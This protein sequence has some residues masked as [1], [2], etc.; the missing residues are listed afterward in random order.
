V[1]KDGELREDSSPCDLCGEPAVTV[2]G[3]Q[4]RCAAHRGVEAKSAGTFRL[5]GS[6]NDQIE[7]MTQP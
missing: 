3:D 1:T 4:A 7:G 5:F 2:E 6:L